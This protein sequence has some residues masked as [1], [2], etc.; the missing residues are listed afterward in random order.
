MRLR[1][2]LVSRQRYWGTPIPIVYCATCG[3]QPVPEDQLPILLPQ[4][5]AFTGEG[6]PLAQL[7]SFIETTCPKC[8]GPAR[9]ESDTMDTFFESSWYYLRYLDPHGHNLP[10]RPERSEKWMNV[11]QYIGGAEHAVLHLLYSRFFYKFFHDRGWVSGSDEPFKRLFHQGMVL[12]NGE[13]MSKSRGN[14]IGI[15]DD[16]RAHRHRCDAPLSALRHAARRYERLDRRGNQR[17]RPFRQSRLAGVRTVLRPRRRGLDSRIAR[18]PKV[19]RRK[20]CC[21]PCTSR[22]NRRVD[23]TSTRRFHFNATV[24]RLDELVNAMTTA[25]KSMP[26][27]PATLYAVH[28]LPVAARAVRSAHRRRTVGAARPHDVGAPRALSRAGRPR[29][30][31]R[32]DHARRPGQRQDPRADIRRAGYRPRKPRVALAMDDSNVRGQIEGKEVRKR[33]YVPDKLLNLVV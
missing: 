4:G 29:A 18:R 17:T 30:R 27:S 19:P 9:R 21:A 28:A 31:G 23:E 3:E 22:R 16:C 33:I 10:W 20:R 2:W 24:A 25:A 32:R 26:D 8:G 7:P 1:D 5:V 14:V 11:D 15:D 13:K 6:S 12:Y